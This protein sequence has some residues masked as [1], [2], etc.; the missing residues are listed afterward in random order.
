MK[1]QGKGKIQKSQMSYRGTW[2]NKWAKTIFHSCMALFCPF[3]LQLWRTSWKCFWCVSVWSPAFISSNL[4]CSSI[5][6]CPCC[7]VALAIPIVSSSG[8]ARGSTRHSWF[9]LLL[10]PPPVR[11]KLNTLP[12]PVML[13][14]TIDFPANSESPPDV[15]EPL[16]ILIQIGWKTAQPA[17][18][19]SWRAHV[20]LHGAASW[21]DL[22]IGVS[23][24]T[25]SSPPSHLT[26]AKQHHWLI[27]ICPGSWPMP[28][29][30]TTSLNHRHLPKQPM[31]PKQHPT[32]W[33]LYLLD[34]IRNKQAVLSPANPAQCSH[35]YWQPNY[36]PPQHQ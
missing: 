8:Y 21:L 3:G 32:Q 25:D 1:T 34:L 36:H 27:I 22:D 26:I 24:S 15:L 14:M 28:P 2:C 16:N 20:I 29:K 18:K 4:V 5:S 23:D 17:Q 7:T 19:E 31:P 10:H 6:C 12:R 35:S 13:L 9:L 30:I 11:R 33:A